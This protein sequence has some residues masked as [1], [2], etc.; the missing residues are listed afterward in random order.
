MVAS[1]DGATALAGT[2]GGLGSPVDTSVL[3]ALRASADV[4]IVGSTT[5]HAE[6]YRAPRKTGQRIGVV[7]ASGNIDV[8]LPLF[9]SG[10]GFLITTAEAPAHGLDVIR[11]DNDA[12][13]L[14]GALARL[15]AGVVHAEGGPTLNAALLALD[16]VDEVNLTIAPHLVG[17]SGL[18]LAAPTHIEALRRMQL[19][20][21]CTHDDYLFARY[22]RADQPG[23]TTR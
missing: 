21:L 19:A 11:S 16:L 9:E 18:R 8:T 23:S 7:T 13:D 22:V 4:I 3:A 10:A 12:V 15:D 2:S 5:A 6:R 14:A 17:G 20:H 1:I